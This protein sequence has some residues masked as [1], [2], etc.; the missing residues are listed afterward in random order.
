MI[1]NW[2]K[3]VQVWRQSHPSGGLTLEFLCAACG[4]QPRDLLAQLYMR[5]IPV[6]FCGFIYTPL[7]GRGLDGKRGFTL[8]QDVKYYL[9]NWCTYESSRLLEM[10]DE[11]WYELL[12]AYV[13]GR[14]ANGTPSRQTLK[15]WRFGINFEYNAPFSSQDK[16]FIRKVLGHNPPAIVGV[17][18]TGRIQYSVATR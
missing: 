3:L 13:H 15:R 14:L 4:I 8:A 6:A 17:S 11:D 2:L 12:I 1:P 9:E 16:A 10:G 5:G 18:R 7:I